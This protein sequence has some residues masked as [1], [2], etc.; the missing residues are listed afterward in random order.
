MLTA[1]VINELHN[2]HDSGTWSSVLIRDIATVH[3][4]DAREVL[5]AFE[6]IR[7]G[8]TVPTTAPPKQLVDINTGAPRHTPDIE[9]A[10]PVGEQ[11]TILHPTP[12]SRTVF[13][14]DLVAPFTRWLECDDHQLRD[15][16]AKIV[17]AI[18]NLAAAIEAADE[19][20]RLTRER[21]AMLA[22]RQHLAA[23]LAE[24]DATLGATD[25]GGDVFGCPDCGRFFPT[26]RGATIHRLRSHAA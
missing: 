19:R 20:A 14:G 6:M 3:E 13:T 9:P 2:L 4:L 1:D 22:E 26:S 15:A 10:T 17:T 18:D 16:A 7:R 24:I 5:A 21:T 12:P 11:P 25:D 8:E 23:R